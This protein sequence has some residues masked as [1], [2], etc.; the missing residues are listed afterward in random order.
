[1][2][3]GFWDRIKRLF[4]SPQVQQQRQAPAYQPTTPPRPEILPP[5]VEAP[6][7]PLTDAEKIEIIA[8]A[9]RRRML[10]DITYDGVSRIVEPYSFRMTGKGSRLF[11][12]FCSI[13]AKIHS[14]NVSKIERIEILNMEFSPRWP[15]EF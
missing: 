13:H 15:I 9:G 7:G 6:K 3:S 11:Y 4:R 10:L 8:D 2:A 5:P 12:G 14:F 1:M